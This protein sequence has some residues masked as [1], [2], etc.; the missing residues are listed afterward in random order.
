M[1]VVRVSFRRFVSEASHPSCRVSKYPSAEAV[2]IGLSVPQPMLPVGLHGYSSYLLYMSLST[3]LHADG[4]S[5]SPSHTFPSSHTR[6]LTQNNYH[7]APINL[8]HLSLVPCF[9]LCYNII[10]FY[11]LFLQF[12]PTFCIFWRKRQSP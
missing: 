11:V 5:V 3:P 12:H 10:I 1:Y 7:R 2:Q 8:P 4:A 9:Q 6:H